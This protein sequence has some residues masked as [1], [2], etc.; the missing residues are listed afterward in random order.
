MAGGICSELL[1]EGMLIFLFILGFCIFEFKSDGGIEALVFSNKFSGIKASIR[2]NVI[3]KPAYSSG[4][5][6]KS[7]RPFKAI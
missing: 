1:S 4:A 6:P 2:I 3:V 7:S 5:S